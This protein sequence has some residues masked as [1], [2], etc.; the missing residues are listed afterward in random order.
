MS[1][2]VV[3][4]RPVAGVAENGSVTPWLCTGADMVEILADEKVHSFCKKVKEKFK[5]VLYMF[6]PA[7]LNVLVDGEELRRDSTLP[8]SAGKWDHCPILVQ[9]PPI[10]RTPAR[11]LV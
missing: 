5:P 4:V 8:S 2:A 7:Q 1:H 6:H 3:W 11:P 9:V 10:E